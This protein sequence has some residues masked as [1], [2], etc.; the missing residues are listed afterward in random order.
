MIPLNWSKRGGMICPYDLMKADLKLQSSKAPSRT[1]AK[2]KVGKQ[3]QL[4]KRVASLAS[5]R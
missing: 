1:I 3:T 2:K 4:A 5:K